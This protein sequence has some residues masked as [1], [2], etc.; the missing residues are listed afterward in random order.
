MAT[1]ESSQKLNYKGVL[2]VIKYSI[3]GSE[4]KQRD[5]EGEF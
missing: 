4:Q 1:E 2:E 5:F 3:I